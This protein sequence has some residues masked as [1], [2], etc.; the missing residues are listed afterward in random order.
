MECLDRRKRI[1]QEFK[2][3]NPV[4]EPAMAPTQ[5]DGHPII[6]DLSPDAANKSFEEESQE[7]EFSGYSFNLAEVDLDR[8]EQDSLN[9]HLIEERKQAERYFAEVCLLQQRC[10]QVNQRPLMESTLFTQVLRYNVV[11][12]LRNLVLMKYNKFSEG[13]GRG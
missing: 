1:A 9:A 5:D 13:M 6:Q 4:A 3:S 2:L 7:D 11:G 8:L 12:K 10:I